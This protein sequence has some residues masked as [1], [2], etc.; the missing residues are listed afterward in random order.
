MLVSQNA[1]F[2]FAVL[3]SLLNDETNHIICFFLYTQ[4]YT[5]FGNLLRCFPG[6][7]KFCKVECHALRYGKSWNCKIRKSLSLCLS[8]LFLIDFYSCSMLGIYLSWIHYKIKIYAWII[9]HENLMSIFC[10]KV[11]LFKTLI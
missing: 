7:G 11:L 10:C 4:D 6:L 2:L 3:V 5:G 9:A 8:I 1:C